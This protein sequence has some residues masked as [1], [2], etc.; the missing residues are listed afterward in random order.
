MK[1]EDWKII[2]KM[3]FIF[4]LAFLL[5]TFMAVVSAITIKHTSYGWIITSI[6]LFLLLV[7]CFVSGVIANMRANVLEDE[8]KAKEG[9]T[10]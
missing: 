4:T 1:V 6:A 7:A 9:K 8:D 5:L 3:L 2:T 10:G